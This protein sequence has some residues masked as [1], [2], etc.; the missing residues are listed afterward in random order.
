M[1]MV[2]GFD[3]RHLQLEKSILSGQYCENPFPEYLVGLQLM[4][5]SDLD[6]PLYQ[7]LLSIEFGF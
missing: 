7:V 6:G 3:P 4:N 1:E 5:R 2:S